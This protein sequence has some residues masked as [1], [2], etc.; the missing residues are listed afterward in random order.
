[1]A[2]DIRLER[3]GLTLAGQPVLRDVDLCLRGGEFVALV[4]PNGAG[5]SSLLRAAAG[6]LK[7]SAGEALINTRPA[8][9]LTPAARAKLVAYLPQA[10]PL[11]WGISV[12]AVAKLGRHALAED[13]A[14]VDHA[15]ALCG[16]LP[17][18]HRRADRLSGG[19]LARTQ[20]ARALAAGAPCL[21]VDEP[22]AALDPLHAWN[23]MQILAEQAAAGALV[24][25]A[26]HDLSLA[27]RFASRIV[28]L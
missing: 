20:L 7:P 3:L 19:E 17:L 24:I 8:H 25:A 5:K 6:L 10:R 21:I 13:P 28:V 18:R 1:M 16:L 27:A 11:A 14:A 9:G 12:E 26:V 15:L 2:V 23:V 22:T 4:G